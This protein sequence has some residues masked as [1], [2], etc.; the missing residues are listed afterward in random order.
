MLTT[1][2]IRAENASHS[3]RGSAA[4]YVCLCHGVTDHDVRRAAESGV[5]SVSELTMRT[6]LGSGC[7]SCVEM[8][9]GL[10]AE[11]SRPFPLQVLAA[12]A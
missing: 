5:R 7:G 6:G 12:A 9:A 8:A 3:H 1:I 4:L 2:R 10:I 11:V